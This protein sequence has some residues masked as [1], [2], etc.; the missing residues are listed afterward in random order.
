MN[1][2]DQNSTDFLIEMKD[3]KKRKELIFENEFGRLSNEK[4]EIYQEEI[5]LNTED[6]AYIEIKKYDNL[7]AKNII[8]LVLAALIVVCFWFDFF[9]IELTF[10]CLTLMV[11]I[12]NF[13]KLEKYYVQIILGICEKKILFIKKK[14]LAEVKSFIKS[15]NIYNNRL[16]SIM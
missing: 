2:I 8:Y 1:L 7:F 15:F 5:I 4:I 16:N 10:F 12:G 9:K 14:D 11:I 6:I 13:I 3:T